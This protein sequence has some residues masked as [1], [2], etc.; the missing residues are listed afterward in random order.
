[1][2]SWGLRI[3]FRKLNRVVI[4]VVQ[5]SLPL[6]GYDDIKNPCIDFFVLYR[7]E[8]SNRSV[9]HGSTAFLYTY[10]VFLAQM[11]GWK[12]VTDQTEIALKTISLLSWGL[13]KMDWGK[14]SILS[15]HKI[16]ISLNVLVYNPPFSLI[17]AISHCMTGGTDVLCD[18]TV[19]YTEFQQFCPGSSLHKAQ[20]KPPRTLISRCSSM[21]HESQQ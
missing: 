11:F 13:F 7:N 15:S 8:E 2:G 6:H 14:W 16:K 19:N 10:Q 12:E 17:C 1:M 5:Y 18:R 3:C 21:S 9:N 20:H 4:Q